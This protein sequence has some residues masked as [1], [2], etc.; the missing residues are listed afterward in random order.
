MAKKVRAGV[1]TPK[2]PS[3]ARKGPAGAV[4]D[5]EPPPPTPRAKAD[6]R[7]VVI[8]ESPTKAKT[9]GKYLGRGYVVKASMG[10]VRD[11]PKGKLGVDVEHGFEPTYVPI[12]DRGK[13]L[14]DL[15]AAT[16]GAREVFLA[17]DPDR[18][19][20]AIAWH[21]MEALKLP[22]SRVRRVMFHEITK[23]AV[24]EA[25][26]NTTT[27]SME[28]VNAQ[29]A[30]RI[31]DRIVGYK[32]SPLLWDKVV[33]GLSAG[34]VQSV[35]VRLIAE[36]EREIA[37]FKPEEYWTVASRCSGAAA[38]DTVVEFA[39]KEW[40]DAP[41]ALHAGADAEAVAT[42]LR[43]SPHV[44]EQV[45]RVEKLE[46]P[47]PPFSTSLLQQQASIRLRYSAK[48][49]MRLAQQLYEGID[50]GE[51]GPVGLITYMRTDSFRVGA[52]AQAEARDVIRDLYGADSVPAEAPH[53]AS[54]KGA[55]AAHEAVR[56]TSAR[57]TPQ[58]LTPYLDPDQLRLYTLVWS[59]FVASQMAPAR[60]AQT[61][62]RVRAGRGRLGA[63]GREVLFAGHLRAYAAGAADEVV[64]PAFR[65]GETLA[66]REVVPTQHFTQPPP[67]YSEATL[68]KTLEKNGI[69][70]P[71]TYAPILSTIQDRGYVRLEKR[72]FHAT[73]VGLVVT[74]LL[75]Q[76]FPEILDVDFTSRM[77]SDLDRIEEGKAEWG[78]VLAKFYGIFSKTLARAK[79][80][81][82]D[83]KR[84]PQKSG[85]PC[86]KCGKE[87]VYLLNRQGR[88][89]GCSGYP[90]CRQ[91]VPLD[92]DG[93]PAPPKATQFP[94]PVC[95]KPYLL[96]HGR[97]GPFLGCS[98]YPEC[99][100]TSPVGPDGK[101]LYAEEAGKPCVKC[102][103]PM[104][105]RTG[106]RGPFLSCSGYP[107]CRETTPLAG[108]AEEPLPPDLVCKD[109][110]S[111]MARR[112][113]RR[114]TFLGCTA[115]PKCR[116]T[117]PDPGASAP[118]PAEP[119]EPTEKDD[120][121]AAEPDPEERAP[122]A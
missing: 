116:F 117:M 68:V 58:S 81:M 100:A 59:R 88:F 71:S 44:V 94:C 113:G 69:G 27:I 78:D 84:E 54:P 6:G 87:M 31:L 97:R 83:L 66:L 38:P 118:N 7:P 3:R 42:E 60:V 8:V 112:R 41:V 57:R 22:K 37:A 48:R 70:R 120:A 28:R 80:K 76:H 9:I 36:R 95:G 64:L 24:E 115:Y 13:T 40:S 62:V 85:Q 90:E 16:R 2:K 73:E 18:E 55:Q 23:K 32:V 79:K 108:A 15:I 12:K 45:E 34:R 121:G 63:Q 61:S 122:E 82:K 39:L 119:A 106:R 109:C 77:E 110:G 43:A 14:K 30:R 26:K 56:P 35:A 52:D 72:R 20:E 104:V 53:Y 46:R 50:V 1:K 105:V 92:S 49:T 103:N 65:E 101:P 17:P 86:P 25:F 75:V 47:R 96:R 74:D 11:L 5:A 19:G 91:T 93:K 21:L 114:G 33:R 89:L 99:R 98:G 107:E 111:P 51:E 67:R 4:P 29:Q 102:G 10:H